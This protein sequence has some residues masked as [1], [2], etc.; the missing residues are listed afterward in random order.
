MNL[1]AKRQK[2]CALCVF[3]LLNLFLLNASAFAQSE[4]PSSIADSPKNQASSAS[5]GFPKVIRTL[6]DLQKNQLRYGFKA[7]KV[8]IEA[9]LIFAA[10]YW[11]VFFVQDGD[12]DAMIACTDA[13]SWMLIDQQV[14]CKLRIVG[15][16]GPNP[17]NII[18]SSLEVIDP[19]QSI[20]AKPVTNLTARYTLPMNTLV[21]VSCD[22]SEIFVSRHG[23]V[24]YSMAG[25]VPVEL[26]INERMDVNVLLERFNGKTVAQGCLSLPPEPDR[27]PTYVLRMMNSA[28]LRSESPSVPPKQRAKRVKVHG[29][30]VVYSDSRSEFVIEADDQIQVVHSR[31]AFRLSPGDKVLVH[32]MAHPKSDTTSIIESCLIEMLANEP[33]AESKSENVA[34]LLSSRP[35]P[36]RVSVTAKIE[37]M[38][39]EDGVYHFQLNSDGN[40]FFATVPSGKQS[41]DSLGVRVGDLVSV[42]GAPML[43]SN[44]TASG[45]SLKLYVASEADLKFLSTPSK[46]P[47][48]QIA[49]VVLGGCAL[50]GCA[51]TWNW[52]LRR[53]VQHRT[54]RLNEVTSHLRKAFEAVHEGVLVND[55]EQRISGFNSQF[56]KM[57]GTQPTEGDLVNTQLN[58][59][60]D[61]LV[62]RVEFARIRQHI[63]D[64]KSSSTGILELRSPSRTLQVSASAI[65]DADGSYQGNLWSFEDITERLSLENKLIQSQKM[66][67]VGQLSGGIAHDFNNLLT[68]I[69]GSLMMMKLA[70]KTNTPSNEFAESAEIAVDRAAELTQHLLDFSRRSTLQLQTIDANILLKRVYLMIRRSIDS[71]IEVDFVPTSEPT[72]VKVDATRLEQVLINLCI[73]ARD[74]LP[75]VGGRIRLELKR[76]SSA[77]SAMIVVNDNGSGIS[78]EVQQRMFEPFFTTK[79]PGCGTGLGLSM[80]I[81]VIEQLKGHIECRSQLGQGTTFEISLPLADRQAENLISVDVE[82]NSINSETLRVLLVDDEEQIRK[83]GNAILKSLGHQTVTAANGREAIDL[84]SNDHTFDVVLLDLTMPVMS[85]KEAFR[86]I[87]R[88]W[89]NLPIAICSGYLVSV[90]DW[91][92]ENFG[93]PP[94]ILAKPYQPDELNAHLTTLTRKS[95]AI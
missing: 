42:T 93:A 55:S 9:Q 40:E 24:I 18:M 84:L 50:L 4:Q 39:A 68:I 52:L 31:F 78:Q 86:E 25:T 57:F 90:D 23:T 12:L 20:E 15:I 2:S 61:Q 26:E 29:G 43:E 6:A 54:A 47:L 85:G 73:N 62:N 22:T 28:Q 35:L 14:G 76:V 60:E 51:L 94:F 81:G 38:E 30:K 74:A 34:R 95:R 16:A 87:R 48:F 1:H 33:L 10:P 91:G 3:T 59:I 19:S 80:A 37:G 49:A 53:Q 83:L 92:D 17:A 45:Q 65:L 21:E 71:S 58:A 69:R 72:Y 27:R 63:Q 32:E 77:K 79:Q 13:A 5:Q 75:A 8:D 41:L 70:A 89:P 7:F 44:P 88:R 66:E 46:L 82:S 36:T 64:S 11:T 56:A 67:A